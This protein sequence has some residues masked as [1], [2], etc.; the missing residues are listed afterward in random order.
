M[1]LQISWWSILGC[2]QRDIFEKNSPAAQSFS[3][4]TRFRRRPYE[5][6]FKKIASQELIIQNQKVKSIFCTLQAQM[7][8]CLNAFNHVI[9]FYNASSSG[10]ACRHRMQP[11]FF[12]RES[13]LYFLIDEKDEL[14]QFLFKRECEFLESSTRS[15]R[16]QAFCIPQKECMTFL[17]Q[18]I[19]GNRT[20]ICLCHLMFDDLNI[21]ENE[22]FIISEIH[23]NIKHP[24]E[25]KQMIQY[26]IDMSSFRID[27]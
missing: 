8:R 17:P 13:F 14:K 16:Y 22:Q 1:W 24:M 6:K 21:I 26:R 19:I 5:L 9:F 4:G 7:I 2:L 10:G 23:S 11:D 20:N 25:C 15:L 18:E 27:D 3:L 12:H